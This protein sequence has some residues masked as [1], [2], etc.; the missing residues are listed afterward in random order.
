MLALSS[1]QAVSGVWGRSTQRGP[2]V[3][4]LAGGKG[5]EPPDFFEK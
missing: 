1:E 5:G 2:G 3:E 4:L